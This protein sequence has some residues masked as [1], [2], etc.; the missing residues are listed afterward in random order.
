MIADPTVS[1][2]PTGPNPLA[3]AWA[4]WRARRVSAPFPSGRGSVDHSRLGTVLEALRTA[5]ITVLPALRNELAAY[6][7]GLAAVD[8]DELTR[9][10]ALAY[11]MN[12]YNAGALDLAGRA[13]QAGAPTVLRVDGAFDGFWAQVGGERLSLNDIEHGKIRRFGDPRIH[14]GL[15]CG[16][17]SCPTLR[18]EP[19]AG[20]ELQPQL[21][22][23]MRSFLARGGAVRDQ[24]GRR[25]LLSRVFLW[26]GGDFTRPRHMPTLLPARRAVLADALGTWMPAAI[27]EW[28]LATG[29]RVDFQPYDWS[30]ACRIN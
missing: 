4:V 5:D 3:V 1:K 18:Y 2:L 15:V 6:R 24:T 22:D 17:A 27:E 25:L 26:Y 14:G 19:F 30:L 10:G 7:D 16:S 9:D 21:D 20:P 12:L 13:T 28:R 8:P 23:Q 29:P 11:W